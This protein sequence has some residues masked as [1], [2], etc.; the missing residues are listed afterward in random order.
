VLSEPHR[1]PYSIKAEASDLLRSLI[2]NVVQSPA[3]DTPN[4]LKAEL[5]NDLAAIS[6]CLRKRCTQTKTL[7]R[8]IAGESMSVV[9]GVHSHLYR[10][11]VHASRAARL[12]DAITRG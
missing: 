2:D 10:T 9:A 5:Y 8:P 7:Q 3:V 12:L 4:G 11:I 1:K 6:Q